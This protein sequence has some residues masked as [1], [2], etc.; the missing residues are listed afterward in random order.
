MP[1]PVDDNGQLVLEFTGKVRN[2]GRVAELT[3]AVIDIA[4][5]GAW[6]DYHTASGH[7]SW[8]EAELDYF[9]MACE[10]NYDDVSR[11]L[12]WNRRAKELAPMMDRD[13][14]E[15]RRRSIDE[16][17]TGWRSPTGESLVNRAVRGGWLKPDG[18]M[19]TPPVPRRARAKARHGA[20]LEEHASQARAERILDE[21][22]AELD[23]LADEVLEKVPDAI[24][25]RY[26]IDRIARDTTRP[27]GKSNPGTLAADDA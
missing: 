2:L 25:R 4:I 17:A 12:A 11:V 23:S 1:D 7:E 6:R 15:D 13:A 10:M 18:R 9:L 3:D 20:T 14:P 22:R 16:A 19:R 26:V 5:S 8:R 21:R 27:R 24:E